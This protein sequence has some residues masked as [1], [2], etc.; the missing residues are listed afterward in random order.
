ML[1]NLMAARGL[2]NSDQF[3]EVP[4]IITRRAKDFFVRI[5]G[6]GKDH[7]G[8]FRGYW[9][10]LADA[11]KDKK[12]T[13]WLNTGNKDQPSIPIPSEELQLVLDAAK[14]TDLE[15]LAGAYFL[16]LGKL[17]LAKEEG[18][19]TILRVNS[20]LYLAIVTQPRP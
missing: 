2:E 13:I 19:K 1:K 9:G 20:P 17:W 7:H 15:D 18:K 14:V 5:E 8:S 10:S 6:V 4:D 16:A 12:G 3:I 11:R